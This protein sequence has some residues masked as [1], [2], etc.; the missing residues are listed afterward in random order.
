LNAER[1]LEVTVATVEHF[2][3]WDLCNLR[4]ASENLDPHGER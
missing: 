1:N 2:A 3:D 4:P